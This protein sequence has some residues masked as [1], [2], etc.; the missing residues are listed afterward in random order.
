MEHE[1]SGYERGWWVVSQEA[2]LWLPQG[3]CIS[4][5]RRMRD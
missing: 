5:T 4:A 3:N 2:K 1:L